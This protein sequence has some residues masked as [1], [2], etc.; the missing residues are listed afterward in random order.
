[1]SPSREEALMVFLSMN[2]GA[3]KIAAGSQLIVETYPDLDPYIK[4]VLIDQAE[5]IGMLVVLS[6][7]LA[8]HVMSTDDQIE[9]AT[10]ELKKLL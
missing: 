6:T 4:R 3:Q 2:E 5:V 10:A 1:M 7:K 9:D 8:E